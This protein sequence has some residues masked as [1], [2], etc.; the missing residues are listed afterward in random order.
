MANAPKPEEYQRLADVVGGPVRVVLT[1]REAIRR[2]RWRAYRRLLET[3]R[4]HQRLGEALITAGA[5]DIA[6]LDSALEEQLETGEKLGELLVRE[7]IVPANKIAE[8]LWAPREAY[9]SVSADDVD[10]VA[11][12]LMGYGL[13]SFYEL[14]P[15]E[16]ARG[17]QLAC[18][19]P[20]HPE[21][22]D[23]IA[24]RI[25]QPVTP[26]LAAGLEVRIALAIA[27]HF[28]WP[29][30]VCLRTA[31]FA[32]AEVSALLDDPKLVVEA[33][34]A[35]RAASGSAA[36]IATRRRCC[37][38]ARSV[39]SRRPRRAAIPMICCRRSLPMGSASG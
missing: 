33:A 13:A 2:G 9:R 19:Y 32:G 6:Q 23:D 26:V 36:S 10:I 37:A 27:S 12:N 1:E 15:I 39:C 8:A 31:G 25:G 34:A 17:I 38:R 4:P 28:A 7:G 24:H 20:I 35:A 30:G 14:V 5:L 16:T 21:V 29:D 22:A 18:P 11:L 3:Q